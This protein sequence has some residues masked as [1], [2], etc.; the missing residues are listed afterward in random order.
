MIRMSRA[1]YEWDADRST[2]TKV[3]ACCKSQL[4]S[5]LRL[6]CEV[7]VQPCMNRRSPDVESPLFRVMEKADCSLLQIPSYSAGLRAHLDKGRIGKITITARVSG[8]MIALRSNNT[9]RL[10]V[11]CT[12]L[13]GKAPDPA[14]TF[15]C[16]VSSVTD[17]DVT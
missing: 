11:S 12:G 17:N 13:G 4:S 8:A 7:V 9:P 6:I 16:G 3:G 2:T 15:G 14:V 1:R 10:L 5:P